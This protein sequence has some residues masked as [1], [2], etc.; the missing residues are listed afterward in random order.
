MARAT[1]NARTAPKINTSATSAAQPAAAEQVQ[2]AAAIA[3][4]TNGQTNDERLQE[5]A[6]AQEGE[7]ADTAQLQETAEAA[8]DDQAGAAQ[9]QEAGDGQANDNTQPPLAAR[10]EVLAPFWFRGGVIK[11]PSWIR[12]DAAEAFAYQEAGVLSTEPGDE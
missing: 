1:K 7:Q 3:G 10:Y 4:E 6:D 8:A 11:P 9:Q 12:M 2:D 5:T